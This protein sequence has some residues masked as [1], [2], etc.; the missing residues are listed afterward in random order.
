M[1]NARGTPN[2]RGGIIKKL[3]IVNSY[4]IHH[5][6]YN[7]YNHTPGPRLV[8][9]ILHQHLESDHNNALPI[10][11]EDSQSEVIH[12]QHIGDNQEL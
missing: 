10:A 12:F 5:N 9:G 6:L 11:S 2:A 1:E 4:A 3:I 7:M 8:A